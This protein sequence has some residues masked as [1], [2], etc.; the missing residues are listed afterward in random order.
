VYW[1][2]RTLA[3]VGTSVA[4]LLF[5]WAAGSLLG[6]NTKQT[7]NA[8]DEGAVPIAT[9]TPPRA[10]NPPTIT[11]A[12]RASSTTSPSATT[13]A[14]PTSTTSAGPPP[15]PGP[16]LDAA[17]ALTAT[18]NQPAY[19][20]GQRP[21]F[22]LSVRN[23][24]TVACIRD[25]SR[26]LRNLVVVPAGQTAPLWSDTDCYT[27]PSQDKPTLQPGQSVTFTLNWAGR[28]SAAGCP[29]RRTA[30]PAGSYAVIA[31]LGALSSAP[32]PFTLTP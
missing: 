8:A 30:V 13:P 23:K 26:P 12:T 1:R 19:R 25:V 11:A 31:K 16:C 6:S 10:S 14:A 27:V 5:I 21:V 9:T 20:V 18:A 15:P 3:V 28:T 7:N 17:I 4:V 29:V 22:T 2:R 24:G 32:A